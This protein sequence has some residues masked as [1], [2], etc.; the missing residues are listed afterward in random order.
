M[1]VCLCMYVCV[2]MKYKISLKSSTSYSVDEYN[3][4]GVTCHTIRSFHPLVYISLSGPIVSFSCGWIKRLGQTG[5]PTVS[6]LD[7]PTTLNI[8][9]VEPRVARILAFLTGNHYD[10]L[11]K[12]SRFEQREELFPERCV[13]F[14][15]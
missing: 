9:R 7:V 14:S 12:T 3:R 15:Y 10:L 1:C 11:L 2:I 4:Y 13:R 8:A 5:C 6:S